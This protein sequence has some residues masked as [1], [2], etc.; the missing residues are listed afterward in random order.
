MRKVHLVCHHDHRATFVREVCHNLEHLANQRWIECAR[1]LIEEEHLRLHGERA[2]NGNTLPLSARESRRILIALLAQS[3]LRQILLC[4]R[5]CLLASHPLHMNGR[6]NTVLNDAQVRE[7]VELLEDHPCAKSKVTN[8]TLSLATLFVEWIGGHDD[9]INLHHAVGGI[10]K[11]VETAQEGALSGPR[12]A[13]DADGL[14]GP[15][16]DGRASQYV[17]LPEPL[18]DVGRPQHGLGTSLDQDAWLL[19]WMQRMDMRALV[20]H[21]STHPLLSL[22]R[23]PAASRFSMRFWNVLK[24]IVS[25]Q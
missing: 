7:E 20:V 4:D 2:R 15:D 18:G 11:E 25:A 1:W 8:A 3:N 13:E 14:S 17:V 5:L 22:L 21:D 23:S 9:T 16:C 6:L 24:M 10:F 12:A 19:C